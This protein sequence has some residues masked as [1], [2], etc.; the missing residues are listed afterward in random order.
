MVFWPSHVFLIG[1]SV[2][3]NN[4]LSPGSRDDS[5][6]YA[7]NLVPSWGYPSSDNHF[8]VGLVPGKKRILHTY[9]ETQ[10]K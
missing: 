5:I 8:A 3:F 7:K 4:E 6:A 2:R 1:K 10:Y 9:W